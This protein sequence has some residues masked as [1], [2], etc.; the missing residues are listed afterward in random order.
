MHSIH[1][2]ISGPLPMIN[3]AFNSLLQTRNESI[4]L[5][6]LVHR[7]G[8]CITGK[9]KVRVKHVIFWVWGLR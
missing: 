4:Q 5:G 7:L 8:L 9:L 1:I 6:T 3:G 2:C